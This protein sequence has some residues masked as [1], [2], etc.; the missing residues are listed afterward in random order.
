MRKGGTTAWGLH[1]GGYIVG[2]YSVG[3]YS[4]AIDFG[5]E[6]TGYSLEALYRTLTAKPFMESL[7]LSLYIYIHIYIYIY[8][9]LFSFFLYVGI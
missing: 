7:S 1:C 4:W 8:V 5:A 3:G 9:S 2:G 6:I